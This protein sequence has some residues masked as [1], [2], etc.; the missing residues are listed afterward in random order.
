MLLLSFL[1][2]GFSSVLIW[3]TS[4]IF[5]LASNYLGRNL[6]NGVK[7]ATINAVGSSV[8]ELFT[9]LIFLFVFQNEQGFASGLATTIGSAAFN[10]LVI[11]AL[12]ILGVL[13]KYP[14]ISIIIEK[15]VLKRD[16]IFLLLAIGLL[17]LILHRKTLGVLEGIVLM[18]FY[19]IYMIRLLK[20]RKSTEVSPFEISYP[21][22]RQNK[23][24]WSRWFLLTKELNTQR[25]WGMLLLSVTMIGANCF[26]LVLGCE[27]LGKE[28][29][30]PI[31][32]IAMVVAAAATSLPDTIL[33]VKDAR[34]GNYDDALANSLGSN[35]FDISVA[36]GLPIL[37][38]SLC[39][40]EI[41]LSEKLTTGLENYIYLLITMTILAAALFL[42][43][44]KLTKIKGYI[45]LLSYLFFI[46]FVAIQSQPN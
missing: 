34:N 2:V 12:V 8:P 3:K 6:S 45:L 18:S 46:I 40:Q 19:G 20:G 42:G 5:E 15:K 21:A 9:T 10:I 35:I 7:G 22:L 30:I 36:L 33:S 26:L 24:N 17:F 14:N 28:L 32:L 44:K 25:A 29:N 4:D 43:G 11:P 31:Y 16:V 39:F 13:L 27:Q 38:Y 37:G 23:G 1:T 41:V